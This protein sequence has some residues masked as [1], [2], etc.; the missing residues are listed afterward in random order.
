MSRRSLSEQRKRDNIQYLFHMTHMDNLASIAEHGLKCHNQ[1]HADHRPRD[2]SDPNVQTH[3]LHRDPIHGRPLH[4]YVPLYFRARN[5]MLYRRREYRRKLCVLY[6][7]CAVMEFRGAI[8]TDGNA[9]SRKTNF[10]E[11]AAD[12][13]ALDWDCLKAEYWTAFDDGA[14]KRCAEVLVPV[15]IPFD[16]VARIVVHNPQA[17]DAAQIAT[18]HANIEIH[19]DWFL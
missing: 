8:F 11:D 5:P 10:Y 19:P 18:S 14:R 16:K 1:A 3:R 2:I 7:D 12:L 17:Q 15:R 9:A 13:D 4:D 6:I